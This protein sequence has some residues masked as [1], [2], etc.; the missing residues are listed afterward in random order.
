MSS[1]FVQRSPRMVTMATQTM[2]ANDIRQNAK[3]GPGSRAA[4][5]D[6]TIVVF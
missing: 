1:S 2:A 6:L 4:A 5:N 3:T